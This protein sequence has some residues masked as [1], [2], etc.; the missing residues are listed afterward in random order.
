VRAV[1]VRWISAFIERPAETL[2][3]TIDF[4][5]AVSG[6]SLSDWFGDDGEFAMLLPR[7][8]ADAHLG[9]QRTRP[10]TTGSHI[11]VHVADV[12]AAAAESVRRGA[13][14]I[15]DHGV[16]LVALSSPGGMPFTLVN[17]RGAQHRQAPVTITSSALTTLVDQVTIDADRDVFD[18]EVAFW[19]AITGWSP[20]AARASEFV[21]LDRP[22]TMPLRLLLQ[23]RDAP[24]GA[25]GCHLD[26]ACDD[27]SAAVDAHVKL[28]ASRV[29]THR[30]WTVMA[31][32][33][34]VEYCLTRR[35]PATGTLPPDG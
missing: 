9:V 33:S 1:D 22:S 34:G 4:W 17:H 26:L 14:V 7:D 20:V 18:D 11:D 21:P 25:T 19:S 30:Y 24:R 35:S 5:C 10:G 2:R 12:R 16:H 23:R 31:D 29:A 15:A 6:S 8:G 13:S 28:G 32:P 27:V 3:V